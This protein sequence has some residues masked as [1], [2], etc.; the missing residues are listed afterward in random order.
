MQVA[1]RTDASL[2]NTTGHVMRCLTLASVLRQMGA[3]CTL[4]C[5]SQPRDMCDAIASQGREVYL[6]P[7]LLNNETA[8]LTAATASDL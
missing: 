6:L 7:P 8:G 1:F 2:L 5:R 4:S 3:T